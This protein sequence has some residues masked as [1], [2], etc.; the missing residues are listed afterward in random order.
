MAALPVACIFE[1]KLACYIFTTFPSR[2]CASAPVM[3]YIYTGGQHTDDDVVNG[4]IEC[5]YRKFC[6]LKLQQD[7]VQIWP[8][9]QFP[10]HLKFLQDRMEIENPNQQLA[11]LKQQNATLTQQLAT[12]RKKLPKKSGVTKI[13]SRSR[14][15]LY[16]V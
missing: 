14:P 12:L 3:R 15:L 13:W 8:A 1:K 11:T 9:N 10:Q 7:D 6:S 16:E 2:S 5:H 4:K